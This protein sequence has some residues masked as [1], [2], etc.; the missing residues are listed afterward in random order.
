MTLETSVTIVNYGRKC[1]ISL[2]YGAK[3]INLFCLKF[4]NCRTKFEC[5]LE[6]AGKTCQRQTL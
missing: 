3:I 1:F 2:D 5:L 6:L 4:T